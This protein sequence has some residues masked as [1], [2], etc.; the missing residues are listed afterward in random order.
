VALAAPRFP[1]RGRPGVSIPRAREG[2][3]AELQTL[4]D[5]GRLAEPAAPRVDGAGRLGGPRTPDAATGHA[6]RSG[7]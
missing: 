3:D 5:G 1:A 7:K 6:R 4:A 2:P